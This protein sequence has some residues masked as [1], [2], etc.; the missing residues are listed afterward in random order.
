MALKSPAI[1]G[2]ELSE[3]PPLRSSSSRHQV[4]VA[5][6]AP[7]KDDGSLPSESEEKSP[8]IN[9]LEPNLARPGNSNLNLESF[10]GIDTLTVRF[11]SQGDRMSS[12]YIVEPQSDSEKKDDTLIIVVNDD[13]TLSV[14]HATLQNLISRWLR[15]DKLSDYLVII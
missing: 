6:Y 14:D 10:A 12:S 4:R 2:V 7:V 13:G 1:G 11:A 5:G 9:Q 15:F 3:E 8:I